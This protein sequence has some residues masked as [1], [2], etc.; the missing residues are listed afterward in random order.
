MRAYRLSSRCGLCYHRKLKGMWSCLSCQADSLPMRRIV[1]K[2][3]TFTHEGRTRIGLVEESE[4]VDLA[5]AVPDLPQEMCAFLRAGQPALDAA[6]NALSNRSTRLRL[7][8]VWLTAVIGRRCRGITRAQVPLAVVG[9]TI[10]NDGSVR[11]YQRHVHNNLG[12]SWDTHGPLGPWIVMADEIADPHN[13]EFRT[14]VNGEVRQ[15]DNTG[16]MIHDWE[17]MIE[18]ASTV[19][20]LEPG[21]VIATGT[22]S[23]V[24]ADMQPP[25]WLQVGDVVRMEVEGIGYLENRVVPEPPGTMGFIG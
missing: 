19:W 4:I 13:L 9:Y 3:A 12:K 8:D 6:R 14:T 18:Y 21:D 5:A 25:R 20:T 23:G 10:F 16:N 1:V 22:C 15:H 24:A 7:S 11:D 2:L 17:K